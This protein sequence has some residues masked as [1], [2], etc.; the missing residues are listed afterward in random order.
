M[1]TRGPAPWSTKMCR[2]ANWPWGPRHVRSGSLPSGVGNGL[3]GTDRP[4]T[5][6]RA[7][8]TMMQNGYLTQTTE[9]R[10]MIVS[11]QGYLELSERI[12]ERLDM[13]LS[14]VEL[15][16]FANGELYA[17]YLE[18]VRGADMFIVQS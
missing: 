9:K 17:R 15:H 14:R 7:S 5:R 4:G 12:A 6:R 11:G 1:L 16:A 2:P 18:S 10:L 8:A 13:D 3:G